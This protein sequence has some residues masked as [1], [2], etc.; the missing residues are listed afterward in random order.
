MITPSRYWREYPQRY[1]LEAAKCKG[2]GKVHF[3][4]RLV[5]SECKGTEFEPVVLPREAKLLSYTVQH[6]APSEFADET[7]YVVGIIGFENGV[8]ATAQ[9][10]DCDPEKLKIGQKL[11]IEFRKVKEDGL[12]GVIC[13]GYKAVPV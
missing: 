6:V 1:R 9:I 10:A 11:R 5:C 7:P 4:P 3:P 13:Y 8:S 2:C 12:A